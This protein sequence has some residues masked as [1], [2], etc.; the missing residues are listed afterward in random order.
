MRVRLSAVLETPDGRLLSLRQDPPNGTPR[1]LL[2][3][4][5]VDTPAT[6]FEHALRRLLRERFG[7]KSTIGPLIHID[8]TGIHDEY[9]F[10]AH[11]EHVFADQGADHDTAH[12]GDHGDLPGGRGPQLG[13]PAPSGCRWD[14]ID[15][16]PAAIHAAAFVPAGVG[17]LL[18]GHLRHGRRPWTLPDIRSRPRPERRHHRTR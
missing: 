10:A 7:I 18:A 3:G 5:L 11:D 13:G 4:G 8:R 6:D 2:P 1:H 9:V 16:T 14:G 12:S 15:L 17:L